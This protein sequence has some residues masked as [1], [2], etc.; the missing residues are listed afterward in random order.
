MHNSL[1]GAA[2][3]FVTIT[4]LCCCSCWH[5]K[6]GMTGNFQDAHI[7]ILQT[8]GYNEN[9]EDKRKVCHPAKLLANCSWLSE[10]SA[11]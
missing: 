4:L 3:L 8:F 1:F 2:I 6:M 11:N 10:C 5:I 7:M 9:V